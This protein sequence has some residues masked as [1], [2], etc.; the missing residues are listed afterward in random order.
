MAFAKILALTK[1]LTF[2]FTPFDANP[3]VVRYDLRGLET[4]LD[5]VADGCGWSMN[6]RSEGRDGVSFY[7]NR[8]I[9]NEGSA[10]FLEEDRIPLR[11][12][13]HS[14]YL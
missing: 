13:S 5:K 6:K 14:A 2:Q 1:R 8:P 10:G 3:A 11:V 7:Q 12:L 4:H 9:R